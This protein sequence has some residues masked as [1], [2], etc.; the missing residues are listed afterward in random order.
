MVFN[1]LDGKC[2]FKFAWRFS[3]CI[4]LLS[5]VCWS[6]NFTVEYPQ[7]V[8]RFE[9]ASIAYLDG[10]L[11]DPNIPRIKQVVIPSISDGQDFPYAGDSTD[12]YPV[13]T[14]NGVLY[15]VQGPG[16]TGLVYK[17]V[18]GGQIWVQAS[19]NTL[20]SALMETPEGNLLGW[21]MNARTLNRSEDGWETTVDVT[22]QGDNSISPY[23]QFFRRW[24]VAVGNGVMMLSEYGPPGALGGRYILRSMDD[25]VT[26][27]RCFDAAQITDIEANRISHW[28]TIG[29]H[30]GTNRWI[31]CS[32]DGYAR[33]VMVYSDDDGD[34]WNVFDTQGDLWVQPV[35]LFDYGDPLYFLAPEDGYA[36]LVKL[37]A[38][39]GESKIVFNEVEWS[40][41]LHYF[42]DCFKH[43]NLYYAIH[44]NITSQSSRCYNMG[45]MVSPDAERWYWYHLF[46]QSDKA[47]M[48][49]FSGYNNGK[50]HFTLQSLDSAPE[51]RHFQISPARIKEMN[52]TVI[53]P[54]VTNLLSENNSTLEKGSGDWVCDP[55]GIL[56]RTSEQARTG[57][58]SMRYT[59]QSSAASNNVRIW[60]TPQLNLV[61]G[62]YY[63]GSAYVKGTNNVIDS[64]LYSVS[65]SAGT[66]SLYRVVGSD[67]TKVFTNAFYISAANKNNITLNFAVILNGDGDFDLYF[68]DVAIQERPMNLWQIGDVP[69]ASD[70]LMETVHVSDEWTDIFAVQTLWFNSLYVNSTIKTWAK[71]QDNYL[72]LGWDANTRKFYLI[73]T[74][75]GVPQIKILASKELYFKGNTVVKF[76]VSVAKSGTKVSYQAG[77]AIETFKDDAIVSLL[78]KEITATY[79]DFPMIVVTGFSYAQWIPF[80]ISDDHVKAAF[81]LEEENCDAG[82]ELRADIN[83]D[84]VVDMLDLVVLAS[85]WLISG[86]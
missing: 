20:I 58:Y 56:T 59:K 77:N 70:R 14:H 25:G 47:A 66:S 7:P 16:H 28:H 62:K 63:I 21:N 39:T 68:D 38:Q 49:W 73:R 82:L 57:Q 9:R 4:L 74:I 55:S 65:G 40:G 8:V 6:V 31:A 10:A 35:R 42:F 52:G 26:W 51:Y 18:D 81:N 15:G 24:S 83:K 46:D 2:Q 3:F 53:T 85:E 12:I 54:A 78:N 11:Y 72:T 33:A 37:N 27:S 41:G 23:A 71:D 75:H 67:W 80:A 50:L 36:G 84:C 17:S 13:I 76:A 19:S 43:E 1:R 29:Y 79:G 22:P 60:P 45:I 32:G 69:K 30:A 86:K 61:P 64:Y 44:A 48:S 34:T 5:K